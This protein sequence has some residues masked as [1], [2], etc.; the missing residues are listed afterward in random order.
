MIL[1]QLRAFKKVSEI[2]TRD[3]IRFIQNSFHSNIK[4]V[5]I[6]TILT[7]LNPVFEI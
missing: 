2:G 4:F 5:T 6:L 1:Q 7:C 3:T